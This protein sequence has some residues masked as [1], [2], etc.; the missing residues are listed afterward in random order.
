MSSDNGRPT[1]FWL[2]VDGCPNGPSWVEV[3]N[4]V[5]DFM[6]LGRGWK[7]VVRSRRLT[8]GQ[9]LAFEYGGDVMLSV[10]IFRAEGGRV[11]C[12]AESDNSSRSSGFGDEDEDEDEENS[13]RVKVEGSSPS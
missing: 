5:D 8:R 3:E 11:D 9:Y 2:Q 10:K 7:A 13:V 12:C 4:T 1:G 6:L